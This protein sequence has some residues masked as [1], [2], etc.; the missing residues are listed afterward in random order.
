MRHVTVFKDRGVYAGWPANHG[1]WQW[2]NE[3]LVGFMLGGFDQDGIGNG[4][5]AIKQPYSKM[6]ARSMDGGETWAPFF[7]GI[8]FNGIDPVP[9]PEFDLNHPSTII[10][11]CGNYDTGGEDCHQLGGF[12]L[13]YDKGDHWRGP[14]HF[15]G[16][17]LVLGGGRHNTSR[18]RVVGR[19][20][21]LSTARRD[22]WGSDWTF[23]AQH[24]GR[25]FIFDANKDIVLMDNYRAVMPAV[26][27]ISDT[28]IVALRRKGMGKN[29]ID[30]VIQSE[31]G[32]PWEL[33]AQPDELAGIASTGAYNGNPPA[34][35]AFGNRLVC[36]YANRSAKSMQF[37][38]SD[39]VGKTWS[40]PC[41]FDR[42]QNADIGYP[43][44]FVRPDGLGACVYYW[45]LM[46]GHQQHIK[47]CIFDPATLQPSFGLG[48]SA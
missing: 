5:H 28:A 11:V 39:D 29:W 36:A 48:K 46:S 33:V 47:A 30:I 40:D 21:F 31:P 2:G 9:A 7:P 32:R 15:T 13:S 22:Q 18:T 27:M 37:V 17:D 43:Q 10:R 12:Y 1:A 14:Y 24:N 44:L 45:S 20:V 19:R 4:M 16:L 26:A 41:E 38:W 25:E 6:L 23:V 8:D 35:A 42:G 3:F 34:L